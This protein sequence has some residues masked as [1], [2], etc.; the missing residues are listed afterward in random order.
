LVER[1][2]HLAFVGLL[3]QYHPRRRRLVAQLQQNSV[4]LHVSQCQQAAS[5]EIYAA[6]QLA[7]NCSLNGDLNLRV[8]EI[9]SAGG[10]LITDRLS[11]QSGLDL[12]LR[13]NTDY[14][15]YGSADEL[16]E[17]SRRMLASPAEALQ[18]AHSGAATYSRTLTS[19]HRADDLLR[20]VGGGSIDAMFLAETRTLQSSVDG[21]RAD[22]KSRIAIY[23]NLQ[24]RHRQF[25]RQRVFFDAELP[26]IYRE[27][28]I[29]LVRL[30][31][32]TIEL[33]KSKPASR[34]EMICDVLIAANGTAIPPWLRVSTVIHPCGAIAPDAPR[35]SPR[36]V[37]PPGRNDPCPCGSGRKYKKCHGR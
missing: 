24:E 33:S 6:A 16:L 37:R 22:L 2:P 20:W 30:D 8:F 11:A 32:D 15:A 9:L 25:E 35:Q 3:G 18:I 27:D 23:E 19:R 1:Q 5:L 4:P 10:C 34:K 14:L 28:A 7:F 13:E 12:L 21:R 36:R 31:V 29:D 17:L 26:A